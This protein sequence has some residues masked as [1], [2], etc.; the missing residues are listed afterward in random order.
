MSQSLPP[1][2]TIE[3]L[4]KQAKQ[5]LAAHKSGAAAVCETLRLLKR[6]AEAADAEILSAKVPLT[7]AQFALAMD[8]GFDSWA[9]LKRHVEATPA[10]PARSVTV[11]GQVTSET[12]GQPIEGVEVRVQADVMHL[13]P[14]AYARTVTDAEGRYERRLEWN[15][16]DRPEVLVQCRH[17]AFRFRCI[18]AAEREDSSDAPRQL[19]PDQR[20]QRDVQLSEGFT[21]ELRVEDEEHLPVAGAEVG[22]LAD[23]GLTV[24]C[25]SFRDR[26]TGTT[27][28]APALVTD[29]HGRL[30]IEGLSATVPDGYEYVLD[31]DHSQYVTHILPGIDKLP[32]DGAVTQVTVRL[33]RGRRLTGRVIAADA[34]RP[35]EGAEVR[36]VY[37]P[38]G[39]IPNG[40]PRPCCE[41][42]TTDPHGHFEM[43]LPQKIVGPLTVSHP[44]WQSA[45]VI[46]GDRSLAEPI[47]VQM[48]SGHVVT[49]QV[50]GRD[51]QPAAD[52]EVVAWT[53][54]TG[55][56]NENLLNTARTDG[57]GRFKLGGLP[58]DRRVWLVAKDGA[59]SYV[60]FGVREVRA[61]EGPVVF[62]GRDVVEVDGCVVD[63]A[64][65]PVS[66][67][68]ACFVHAPLDQSA[69]LLST[70]NPSDRLGHFRAVVPRNGTVLL[71][72][73]SHD[74]IFSS[75]F[76]NTVTVTTRDGRLDRPLTI[77]AK[78][79]HEQSLKLVDAVDGHP[80]AEADITLIPIHLWYGMWEGYSD[81]AGNLLID[82]LPPG[83]AEVF[84][85]AR[86]YQPVT[87]HP[88]TVPTAEKIVVRLTPK[89]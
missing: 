71:T 82:H 60:C 34:D 6:F 39:I 13:T 22:V 51:G 29:A 12:T 27:G 57:Q 38:Y 49:G 37:Y 83:E 21:L 23:N 55:V 59:D 33:E 25:R 7:D 58:A 32:R 2:P 72:L 3:A 11:F 35:I 70:V 5:L 76:F 17:E 41:R 67:R 50:L 4:K 10:G 31:V 43:G 77:T 18:N 74:D 53:T 30:R 73:S 9:A 16:S 36:Y 68:V 65:Q 56:P 19:T 69:C 54:T 44:A 79:P 1:H 48:L 61:G 62:D 26:L 8:Y 78:P 45:E 24:S 20:L 64:G 80:I 28:L 15:G 42:A 63:E 84:V 89:D 46:L 75:P 86:G 52:A 81:E 88:A 47:T 85:V 14:L 40:R 66:V 87:D